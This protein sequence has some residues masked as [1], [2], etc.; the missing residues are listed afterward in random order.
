MKDFYFKLGMGMH[1]Y[2]SDYVDVLFCGY[3][4]FIHLIMKSLL[5]ISNMPRRIRFALK[6]KMLE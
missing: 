2:N 3:S 4:Q 5:N 1:C 6:H